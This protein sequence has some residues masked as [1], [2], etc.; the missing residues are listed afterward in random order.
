MEV[1]KWAW[2]NEPPA[3][4]PRARFAHARQI[5]RRA[6][7]PAAG[8]RRKRASDSFQPDQS[9]GSIADAVERVPLDMINRNCSFM[10]SGYR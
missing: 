6:L 9:A 10:A 3:R 7:R 4:Q 8:C 5:K 2:W 1:T